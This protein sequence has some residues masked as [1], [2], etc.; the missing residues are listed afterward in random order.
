M[1]AREFKRYRADVVSMKYGV[2]WT[3]VDL[4]FFANMERAG[5]V[6]CEAA[7]DWVPANLCNPLSL[8]DVLP[9]NYKPRTPE[10]AFE[11]GAVAWWNSRDPW[12]T[13]KEAYRRKD[14]QRRIMRGEFVPP[15]RNGG[16]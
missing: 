7:A 3:R 9:R 2:E 12:A 15:W 14:E 8:W 13:G 6:W 5:L 1:D 4:P 16:K 10:T 11:G